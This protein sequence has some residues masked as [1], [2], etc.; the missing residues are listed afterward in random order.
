MNG[1]PNLFIAHAAADQALVRECLVM[2]LNQRGLAPWISGERISPGSDWLSETEKALEASDWVLVALSPNA[3]KS[4]WVRLEFDW[5]L[6]HR[7]NGIVPLLIETCEWKRLHLGI[8]LLELVDL[9]T[10][11]S[12]KISNLVERLRFRTAEG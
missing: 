8:R 3:L 5:A 9:R 10:D 12:Q 4:Q 7:R 2:P 6:E 1:Q 11:F